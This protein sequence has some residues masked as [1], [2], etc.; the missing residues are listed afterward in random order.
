MP[1]VQRTLEVERVVNLVKGFGWEKIEESLDGNDV[2]I[3][4]KKTIKP[5]VPESPGS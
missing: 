2:K 4:I 3:T 5:G 1:D